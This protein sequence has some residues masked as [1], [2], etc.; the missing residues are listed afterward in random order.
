[1][2]FLKLIPNP[3]KFA[4]ASALIAAVAFSA[5]NWKGRTAATANAEARAAKATIQQ[6]KERGLINEAVD[7][8]D[9]ADIC[10]ELGGVPDDCRQ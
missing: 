9:I 8:T 7:D 6:L 3:V 1:M 4:A 5:G 10:I 2:A